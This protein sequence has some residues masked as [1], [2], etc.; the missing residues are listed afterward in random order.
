MDRVQLLRVG[1]TRGDSRPRDTWFG[2]RPP[3]SVQVLHPLAAF[4]DEE[5]FDI[6]QAD[7]TQLGSMSIG[8]PS[9]GA[10]ANGVHFPEG[11]HWKLADP[12][13]SWGTAESVAFVTHA[14]ERVTEE[15]PGG[16]TVFVGDLSAKRGGRLWPHKSHQSGRDVDIGYFYLD[17]SVWYRRVGA[18]NMDRP[19]NWALLK[20]LLAETSVQYVFIDRNVQPLLEEYALA[21]GEDPEWVRRLFHGTPGRKDSIIRHRWGH[22]T[23]MHVRFENPTAELT[24]R[25]SYRWLQKLGLLPRVEYYPTRKRRRTRG[26]AKG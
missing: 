3:P 20:T 26:A 23:H 1:G 5:I 4:T 8:T 16:H 21:T 24:G 11:P 14:I 18:H 9:R 25:R 19:R 17:E 6:A 2:R 10:L 15:L 7:I 12:D 13:H 22:A